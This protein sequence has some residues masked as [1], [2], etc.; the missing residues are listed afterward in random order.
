MDETPRRDT[1]MEKLQKLTPVQ[2]G[3]CTAGNSS[4]ENDA[5]ACVV[6][7]SEEAAKKRDVRPMAKP[8]GFGFV[9]A[10]PRKTYETVPWAINQALKNSDLGLEKMDLVEIQ[11]AFAPQVLADL[12]MLGLGQEEHDRINANGSGISLGHPIGCTGT[13]VLVTLVRE[14]QRRGVRYGLESICGGGG[15]GIAAVL[16]NV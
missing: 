8:R 2:N 14:M 1:A 9:G 6:L 7:M 4:S 10:D 11:E 12:K 16:E 13:R 5:A 15:L 3:V